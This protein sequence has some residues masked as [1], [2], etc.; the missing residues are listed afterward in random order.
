[1][2]ST[3]VPENSAAHMNLKPIEPQYLAL[4]AVRP[5]VVTFSAQQHPAIGENLGD[6]YGSSSLRGIQHPRTGYCHTSR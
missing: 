1:L 5:L 4:D 2:G 3:D 6:G